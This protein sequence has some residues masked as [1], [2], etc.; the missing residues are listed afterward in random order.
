M[1]FAVRPSGQHSSGVFVVLIPL[2]L[3]I[4]C[5]WSSFVSVS[6]TTDTVVS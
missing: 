5:F 2:I 3:G 6:G 4:R 1:T